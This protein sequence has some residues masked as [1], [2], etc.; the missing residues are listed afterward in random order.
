MLASKEHVGAIIGS[1]GVANKALL[2]KWLWR[3][4]H[5][6]ITCG[7]G[8][9]LH[10]IYLVRANKELPLKRSTTGPWKNILK[11][12]EDLQSLGFITDDW[13]NNSSYFD[14]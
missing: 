3:F 7:L 9:L 13:I 12:M 11:N 10:Y 1:P 14:T 8:V 4:K 5:E 2:V 6:K